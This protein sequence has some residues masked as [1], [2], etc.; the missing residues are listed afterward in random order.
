MSYFEKNLIKAKAGIFCM[1]KAKYFVFVLFAQKYPA[2]IYL[3]QAENRNTRT[4]CEIRSK[5]TTKT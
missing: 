3:L 5:L 4:R 2:C 1:K